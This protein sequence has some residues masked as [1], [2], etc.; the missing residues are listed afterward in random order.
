MLS[1][2]KSLTTHMWLGAR[3]ASL[4]PA[5]RMETARLLHR[6][7]GGQEGVREVC[8]RRFGDV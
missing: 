6:T 4:G 2:G 5:W 8:P 3:G 1:L 7:G